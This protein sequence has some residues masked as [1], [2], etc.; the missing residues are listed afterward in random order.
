MSYL[1]KE[2]RRIIDETS[3][4]AGVDL[5]FVR[6][7]ASNDLNEETIYS[8][9]MQGH[10]I[11]IFG[12]GTHLVTCQKQPAL[13]CVFKLVELNGKPRIKLSQSLSKIPIPGKKRVYRVFGSQGKAICDLMDLAVNEAPQIGKKILAKHPF[14]QHKKVFVIPSKVEELLCVVFDRGEQVCETLSVEAARRALQESLSTLRE[15]HLR[16]LNPTP[17]KVSVTESLYEFMIDI[18]D[19]NAPVSVMT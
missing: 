5:S 6:I 4:I 16:A 15:D 2:C 9:N 1:S 7:A 17:Y 11:D 19:K 12:I 14:D 18:I 10:E 8:L 13:G 3:R